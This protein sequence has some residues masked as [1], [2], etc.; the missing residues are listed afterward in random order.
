MNNLGKL[1]EDFACRFLTKNNFKIVKRNW[2]LK[3]FGEIDIIALKNNCYYFIEVKALNKFDPTTNYNLKKRNKFYKLIN[4]YVNKNKIE[5]FV[6]CLITVTK[7]E[8]KFTI[9]FFKNV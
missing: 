3:R 9:K 4:F 8:N 5:N 2:W 1:A 6:S 7:N